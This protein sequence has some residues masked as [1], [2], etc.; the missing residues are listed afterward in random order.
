MSVQKCVNRQPFYPKE[1]GL[2]TVYVHDIQHFSHQFHRF[3]LPLQ[4]TTF[5]IQHRLNENKSNN[6]KARKKVC[7]SLG[8]KS[9]AVLRLTPILASSG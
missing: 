3:S 7:A 4:L 1:V 5:H 6:F 2:V 9:A 8:C